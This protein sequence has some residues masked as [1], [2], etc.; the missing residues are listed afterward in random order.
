MRKSLLLGL[1]IIF[2]F[3]AACT[4]TQ[5]RTPRQTETASNI[6]T[7]TT[8]EPT[9]TPAPEVEAPVKEFHI[10]AQQFQF[11]PDTITVNKGD[12]VRIILTSLDVEHGFAIREFNVNAAVSKGQEQTIEFVADNIGDFD[13]FCSVPCG[14]GHGSMRGHLIV[15]G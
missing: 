5:P 14:S 15:Q 9:N 1:L 3:V 10:T 12:K 7:S 13:F 11:D 6:P 4:P 8:P 2:L